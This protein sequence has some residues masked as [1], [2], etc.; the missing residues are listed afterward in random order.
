MNIV[1]KH[2]LKKYI[3]FADDAVISIK[4]RGWFGGGELQIICCCKFYIV[5][6][7]QIWFG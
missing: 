1:N 7:I 6:S 5:F 3:Q 4:Y 2:E